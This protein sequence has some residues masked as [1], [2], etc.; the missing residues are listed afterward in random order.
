LESDLR[1]L[2]VVHVELRWYPPP[3]ILLVVCNDHSTMV[4]SDGYGRTTV[5]EPVQAQ[6]NPIGVASSRREL[7][8]CKHPSKVAIPTAQ[9]LT[10]CILT[11][12][13]A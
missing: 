5:I 9:N 12:R 10:D 1:F 4:F 2:Y 8:W 13:L 7:S 11:D 6:G 3:K